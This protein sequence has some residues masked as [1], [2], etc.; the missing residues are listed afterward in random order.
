M[1]NTNSILPGSEKYHNE[2]CFDGYKPSCYFN[3]KGDSR[4]DLREDGLGYIQPYEELTK[5][6]SINYGDNTMSFNKNGDIKINDRLL[7]NDEE[8]V[9]ALRMLLNLK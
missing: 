6:I 3:A 9:N 7:T 2:D 5:S 4:I 8:I 1:L